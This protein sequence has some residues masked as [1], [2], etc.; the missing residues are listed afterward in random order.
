MKK[1]LKSVV[2]AALAAI[3]M[4]C[5]LCVGA[6]AQKVT[7]KDAWLSFEVW[8]GQGETSVSIPNDWIKLDVLPTPINASEFE[9]LTIDDKDVD[10]DFFR[11]SQSGDDTV[12]TLNESYLKSFTA[13]GCYYFE[14]EFKNAVIPLHLYVVTRQIKIMDRVYSFD[15]YTGTGNAAVELKN[16]SDIAAFYPDLFESLTFNGEEVAADNYFLKS[17]AGSISIILYEDYLKNFEP[18]TYYFEANFANVAGVDLK[19]TIAPKYSVGDVNGDGKINAKDARITL[20]VA[21]RLESINEMQKM[22]A[23]I[24]NDGAVTLADARILLRIY[25]KLDSLENY[26]Q[27]K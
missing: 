4:V 27:K 14:A 9:K 24:N 15:E 10:E 13:D 17:F 12:I 22:A 7:V 11:V 23:D 16:Y 3:L 5:A 25:A 18:G 8:R 20:R 2:C 21:A 6:S 1:R 19:L 26:T